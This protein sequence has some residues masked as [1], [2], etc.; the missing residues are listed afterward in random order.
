M[1]LAQLLFLVIMWCLTFSRHSSTIAFRAIALRSFASSSRKSTTLR[2][3]E[4]EETVSGYQRPKVQWYP[5][6][7][8]KAERQLQE[9]ISAVDV[10]LEVRDAR[11]PKATCH[12]NVAT[13]CS[14]KPRIVVITHVDTVPKSATV[15]WKTSI[16][17][18]SSNEESIANKQIRNQ[19][20]QARNERFKYSSQLP[21][22]F[23]ALTKSVSNHG[24]SPIEDVVFVNAKEGTGIH[25]L[26]RIIQTAGNHV[27]VRRSRRGLAPRPLRVG[28]L[29]FPNVG[30]S[31]LINKILNRKRAATANTPGVTRSLQWIRVQSDEYASATGKKTPKISEYFELLDS[32]GIIPAVLEDQS[33]ALLLAACNCIGDAAYDNQ[34][35]AV[36]LC[37]WLLGIHRLG[38]QYK[39]APR[40]KT[41]FETRYGMNPLEMKELKN[42]T[43]TGEHLLFAVADKTCQGDPEDAS[44]KILQDFRTGRMG[45]ICLQIPDAIHGGTAVVH[46]DA[47]STMIAQRREEVE[48]EQRRA[49]EQR[50]KEAIEMAKQS[51]LGLPPLNRVDAGDIGKGI[52]DGW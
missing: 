26:K 20:K 48:E 39:V 33:D 37:D 23:S 2:N 7:I 13:W 38:L 1:N 15:A 31:A 44:R 29:G 43:P 6:H 22:S 3:I 32:P 11:I 41:Q 50:A 46:E 51:G 28:I 45:K 42:E 49:R 12:P 34:A 47:T 5:G 17:N 25:A 24:H 14:G 4:N 19:A 21:K 16:L 9:T 30:K 36:Y 40:W 18:N 35:V 8:A 27:T 10:V 52:F